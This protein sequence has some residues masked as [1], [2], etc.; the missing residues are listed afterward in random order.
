MVRLMSVLGWLIVVVVVIVIV[1]L[2]Y[3]FVRR[4]RRA[5]HVIATRKTKR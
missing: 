1:A 3:V 4:R 5:G 2:G